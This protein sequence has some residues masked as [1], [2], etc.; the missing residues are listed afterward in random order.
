MSSVY[1]YVTSPDA[2]QRV[3]P[4]Q[5]PYSVQSR[6]GVILQTGLLRPELFGRLRLRVQPGG[7]GGLLQTATP[8]QRPVQAHLETHTYRHTNTACYTGHM[9]VTGRRG[10]RAE[11]VTKL[12]PGLDTSLNC[13][14][15]TA[16]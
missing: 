11:H 15:L 8:G 3:G 5:S 6:H 16:N 1:T 12:Q 9:P 7:Q 13:Q 2:G 10:W 14:R 4:H